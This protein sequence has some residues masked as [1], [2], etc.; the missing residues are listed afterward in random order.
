LLP[1][2]GSGRY[3]LY[4]PTPNTGLHPPRDAPTHS[5]AFRVTLRRGVR[6]GAY[7]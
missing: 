1:P 5:E 4:L 2:A 7:W 6:A 3:A